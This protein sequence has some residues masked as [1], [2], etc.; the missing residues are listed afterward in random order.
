MGKVRKLALAVYCKSTLLREAGSGH[1]PR[2][3][4]AR[5]TR[6]PGI[7]KKTWQDNGLE[8]KGSASTRAVTGRP[9]HLKVRATER[10]EYVLSAS[11]RRPRFIEVRS[12]KAIETL[13][14]IRRTPRSRFAQHPPAWDDQALRSNADRCP[15]AY[16]R[17]HPREH[18]ATTRTAGT[19]GGLPTA[20]RVH[21][22]GWRRKN[23]AHIGCAKQRAEALD[24]VLFYDR[25]G[26]ST[27]PR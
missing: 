25:P 22:P 26:K 18:G 8:L 20:R 2:R 17:P 13:E 21:R 27:P 1:P 16:G 11:C 6:I 23:P 14:A 3:N 4:I 12:R 5:L 15:E 7:G 9:L 24:H 19:R 10:R